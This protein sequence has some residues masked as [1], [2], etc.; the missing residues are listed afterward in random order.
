[1]NAKIFI[2]IIGFIAVVIFACTGCQSAPTTGDES[3]VESRIITAVNAERL[4]G[5]QEISQQLTSGLREV[6]Q[7]IDSVEGGLQQ[8]TIAAREYRQFVLNIIDKL[9]QSESELSDGFKVDMETDLDSGDM[10][11]DKVHTNH[12]REEV[13][14]PG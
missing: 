12:N 11:T 8:V 14:S 1:M 7:R 4:R 5:A 9:Q 13:Q 6:E 3:L 10:D 2:F